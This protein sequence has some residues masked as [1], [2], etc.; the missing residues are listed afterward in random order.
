M[1]S[2]PPSASSVPIAR[3]SL[4]A[5]VALPALFVAFNAYLA[6][7]PILGS[8]ALGLTL[9]LSVIFLHPRLYTWR[10]LAP[11]LLTFATFVIFP[12]AYTVYIGFTNYSSA[13]LLTRAD[14]ERYFESDRLA[15]RSREVPFRL[16]A[17][18]SGARIEIDVDGKT[19]RS[20]ILG[21]AESIRSDDVR[22]RIA[23][24]E[25]LKD[26]EIDVDGVMYRYATLRTF[27]PIE[28]VWTRQSDGSFVGG[29]GPD[30]IERVVR[31]DGSRG[32]FV[33]ESGEAIGPG[34]RVNVGLDNFRQLL[35]SPQQRAPLIRIF[36][37]TVS[38]A[39]LS[40]LMSAAVGIV[41][42]TLLNW[43][44]LRGRA[45]YRTLLI[46][47]YAIPAFIS[48]L[49][50]RGLFNPNPEL[51]DINA[52][53]SSIFGIAPAWT[54]DP[55]L[56]RLM[57]LIVNTWLGYP[58]M[59]ILATGVLQTVPTTMYEAADIDGAGTAGKFFNMT[60]PS[61]LPT[62][63]PLLVGS[64]AFNFNNFMLVFLLTAG[65]PP[66][67]GVETIAGETDLLV[68]YTYRLAFRD[69]A[70]NFGY[71]S[72]ISTIIFLVV[73]LLAYVNLKLSTRKR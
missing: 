1:S 68:T 30:G 43:P 4:V 32:R 9:L 50:F 22:Q 7:A 46:V 59:M 27:A 8:V 37:W 14:V 53:L 71:A 5:V 3:I 36:F 60:L 73:A 28:R 52:M 42:A 2:P 61:I 20:G 33:T 70:A 35:F 44:L 57:C 23:L 17:D 13:N 55:W 72:A 38:F 45:V 41:L 16:L 64:F 24:R 10:Y 15:D 25:K 31:P 18:A 12:L 63:L 6:G 26:V 47:P 69:S 48:I 40:V 66:M 54:T 19:H 49:I 21:T 67:A 34:Y 51:G 11:G 62:M 65:G 29:R 58:Y 56:A 39:L